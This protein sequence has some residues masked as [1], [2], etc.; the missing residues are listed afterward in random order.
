M[1]FLYTSQK[2]L[3]KPCHK[4]KLC[5]INTRLLKAMCYVCTW[6]GRV[7]TGLNLSIVLACLYSHLTLFVGCC[8]NMMMTH[9]SH[10]IKH[11]IKLLNNLKIL[12]Y[13]H[14]WWVFLTMDWQESTADT[15]E[16][17]SVDTLLCLRLKINNASKITYLP[18]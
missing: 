13:R 7:Q 10:L 11:L 18:L 12:V 15:Y 5:S 3:S 6:N 4:S 9:C 16:W 2:V 8:N 1:K 17:D 14:F